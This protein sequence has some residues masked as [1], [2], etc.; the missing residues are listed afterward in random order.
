MSG[1]QKQELR[2]EI[3]HVL[4]IDI[5]GYS[6]LLIDEQSEALEELNDVVRGTDAF[7]NAHLG[8]KLISL[9]TG[10][11][12]ALVF[13]DSAEA[14]V[15]C[16]LQI[17][18]AL[19][20]HPSMAVR[21]GIHSGPVHEVTDVN[22]RK[23]IAGAGI[24][25]AQRVMD[26]GDAGH[27][28]LSKRV[29]D[30]LAQYR[31]WQPYLHD[32]GECEVKHGVTL[33]VV[34]FYADTVGNP[35]PPV[36]F[37]EAG[38][39]KPAVKESRVPAL[40]GLFILLALVGAGAIWF[41][42]YHR[43]FRS[44]NVVA[45][46]PIAP[47]KSIAVL[48]FTNL[49][50]NQ[51]NAFF[52][53]GVQDDILTA[54]AKVADLRVI[55]RM[56]VIGYS[57][58]KVRNLREVG[59]ALGVVYLLE[60]S[61]R[62]AGD[63]VRVSAQ[64]IDSRT[65]AHV[66]AETY[67]RDLADVFAIQS[68]IAQQIAGQ[69]QA[70]L[71][72]REK[73]AIEERPTNDLAAYDLYARAKLLS[74]TATFNTR[75]RENLIE[76]EHLLRQAIQRDP[77][78][79]LAYV[80]LVKINNLLYLVGF[81]HT[82]ARRASA[83]AAIKDVVRLRPDSGETH[84]AL[85]EY[86][87]SCDLDYNKARAELTLAERT[88]PNSARISEL[89]GYIAR[90][91]GNWEESVRN[92]DRALQLDP[93]NLS[94]LQQISLCYRFLRRYPETAL[95]LDRALALAPN[96]APTRVDRAFVEL[97]WRADPLPLHNAIE[98]IATEKPT[99]LTNVAGDWFALALCQRDP[100]SIERAIAALPPEGD[101]VDAISFPRG[102]CEGM[103]ARV[104]GDSEGARKAFD[105]ARVEIDQ[106]LRDQPDFGPAWCVLGLI[107][108]ALGRKDEAVREGRHAC[109]LLP[110]TRDAVN[111]S[112][113][114]WLLAVIYAWVGEKDLAIRQLETA[115]HTPGIVSY[116]LLKLHPYWD[117]LRGDPR[118]EKIVESLAPKS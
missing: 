106:T 66:W 96:D 24:N 118:F 73:A 62:R 78:F 64:L 33:S 15:D 30:D 94:L 60:G 43:P 83:D 49:S 34:N 8:G 108:A 20:S 85:A 45:N 21:I 47:E 23:N 110:P 7:K 71:S 80:Q 116:G 9:P 98:S 14:P 50:A 19:K 46:P 115:V 75:G 59:Q 111:G 54:L 35:N 25:T 95:I 40:I 87:Y 61:V 68:D 3:A 99:E 12:M 22:Q 6:K 70:K 44:T 13:T 4:F 72:V 36:K 105:S 39:T 79:F 102:F 84:V 89:G 29:G 97:L 112:H 48:P 10:D 91:E 93:R 103:A 41:F 74:D 77:D 52:A 82:P 90:R 92:L 37:R 63:K 88:L 2:L 109:E 81:D 28:L 5:V 31:H 55:S 32:L 56:S 57:A 26:C 69:L 100:Q 114:L 107:D 18:Q 86:Y 38:V 76:A 58:G 1:E 53:D 67:D 113:L 104:R 51:E 65:D 101:A 11:G 27:I 42:G 117:A 16:A 17:T